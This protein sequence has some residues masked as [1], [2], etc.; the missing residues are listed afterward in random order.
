[1]QARRMPALK[2]LDQSTRGF[3][4]AIA[5]LQ[6][7]VTRAQAE[8]ATQLALQHLWPAAGRPGDAPP[9]VR[10]VDG[11]RGRLAAPRWL[12][13]V[14]G[15][16]LAATGLLLMIA[17]VNVANLLLARA[18]A[19]RREFGVRLAIGASRFALIR[20][21]LTESALLT[22]GQRYSDCWSRDGGRSS[23]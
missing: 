3:G 14:L 16:T 4:R 11:S 12:Q 10:L 23:F 21:L 9:L 5:R 2:L 18:A 17:C 15:A 1:M 20:Q 19:R 22:G 8:A 7:G 6:P 13:R